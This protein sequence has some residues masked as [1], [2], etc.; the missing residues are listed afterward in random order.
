MKTRQLLQSVLFVAVIVV[1]A[2]NSTAQQVS[3]AELQ[4]REAQHKQQ[5]EGD[6]AAAIKLYQ[7]IVA[8]KT[9]DRTVKAKA[10]LQLA[11]CYEK[12]GRQA[13]TVYQQIVRDF[14]DQP[15]ATQARAKIAALR[16]P[17][18]PSTMTL[19]R[20]E[21]GAGIQNVVAT[22]GQR[23]VFWDTSNTTLWIGDSAGKSKREIYRTNRRPLT[24]VSRDLNMVFFYFPAFQQEPPSY[25]VVKSDG[26]G[27]RNLELVQDGK[28]VAAT[29][30]ACVTWSWDNRYVLMC[31]RL[32]DRIVHLFK[33]S[34]ADGKVQDLVDHPS[35]NIGLAEF[36]PD[37]KFIAYGG[38]F[39]G[40]LQLISAQGGLPRPAGVNGFV[41]DWSRDGRNLLVGDFR[42][43]KVGIAVIPVQNGQASPEIAFVTATLPAR[44]L[45]RTMANGTIVV[46]SGGN[47]TLEIVSNT[48]DAEGR[49]G[50]WK[51]FPLVDVGQRPN[52]TWS[53]DSRQ[54]AYH[55]V[56]GVIRLRD[57]TSGQDRELYRSNMP[58]ILLT[59]L[60][61]HQTPS[62]YCGQ[63]PDDSQTEI[64][65]VPLTS[66]RVEQL[67][68]IEGRRIVLR[69]S[70]DDKKLYTVSTLNFAGFEWEIGTTRETKVGVGQ[71]E[72]YDGEWLA[73]VTTDSENKRRISIRRKAD[74]DPSAWKHLAYVR[75]Q[76][77]RFNQVSMAFTRDG[78]WIVYHDKD[79]DGKDGLFRVSISG[80]EPR[81]LG[82]YPT[83]EPGSSFYP[84]ADGSQVIVQIPK[85]A[86][87]VE[88]WALD[89]IIPATRP[90]IK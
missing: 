51:P 18:A 1:T 60:W 41:S 6:L 55:T 21:L 78:K 35:V 86:R 8:S 88:F 66:G 28:P 56:G 44:A 31:S 52:I 80:G 39:G 57:V 64:F 26:T 32:A 69:L 82:D 23:V 75:A 59:C 4:L 84:S 49:L 90:A 29:Q 36:S 81:R 12:Q 74:S 47:P 43:D 22:D 10:L 70:V 2:S 34:I 17:N 16:S 89:N 14:A 37:D 27:F 20:I 71:F 3:Q 9:A 76:G 30:P 15:A 13:N 83:T 68:S 65:S 54:I 48:V 67:G 33:V 24:Y 50:A 25:A 73:S 85:P 40:P 61:A 77:T 58:E 46:M 45:P 5:V 63:I 38:T 42:D 11:E 53:P 87:Q 62:L 7:E 72:S 19:R 79:V